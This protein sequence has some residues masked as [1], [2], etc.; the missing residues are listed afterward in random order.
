MK[1]EGYFFL[2]LKGFL[3]NSTF[4]IELNGI[5]GI[6]GESGSGK[7]TFL[8]CITGLI[9]PKFGFLKFNNLIYQDSDKNLF[10]PPNNR[11]FGYVLQNGFLFNFMSVNEN[12]KI[13]TL[14]TINHKIDIDNLKNNFSFDKLLNRNTVN[15]SGGEK[16]RILIAQMLVTNP[17]CIILD[18]SFSA[19]DYNRKKFLIKFFVNLNKLKKIPI[20]F[21]SHNIVDIKLFVNS[22]YYIK[23][24]KLSKY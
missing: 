10:I 5:I 14:K 22:L 20:I 15:L 7:S 17:S 16:Q 3:L 24:G 18:E 23:N 2:K 9:H 6:V 19:Q 12:L 11:E 13:A 21:V 1:I 4:N 8:K